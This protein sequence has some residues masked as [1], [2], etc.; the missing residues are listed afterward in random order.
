[1]KIDPGTRITLRAGRDVA[2]SVWGEIVEI[3][4]PEIVK[5][6]KP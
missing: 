1:M 2:G 3:V 4:Q 5:P 6:Q